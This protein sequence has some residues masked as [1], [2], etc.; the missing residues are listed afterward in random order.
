M[1]KII[2]LLLCA[3]LSSNLLMAEQNSKIPTV[4]AKQF[5]ANP[6]Q[7]EGQVIS[8]TGVAT[9][10]CQS[11][12]KIFLAAEDGNGLVRVNIEGDKKFEKSLIGKDITVVGTVYSVDL[13]RVKGCHGG[14]PC[15]DDRKASTD[16]KIVY[17]VVCQSYFAD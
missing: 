13:N 11:L 7:Y 15:E 5:Y 2:L 10:L 4:T 17:Y 16:G 1:K 6:T 9:Q 8:L 12:K 3:T 14:K